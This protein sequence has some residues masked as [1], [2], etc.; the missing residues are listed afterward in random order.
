MRLPLPDRVRERLG[1]RG[2]AL[3]LAL[4]V[5]L[6]LALLL[7]FLT[8]VIPGKGDRPVPSVFG[9]EAGESDAEEADRTP[10]KASERRA[11]SGK[12]R[13][14]P[15]KPA[16]PPPEAPEPPVPPPSLPPDFVR[17][18]RPDFKAA[19]IAGKGS[20]PRA[21]TGEREAEATADSGSH[22]GDSALAGGRGP[23][24]EPLYAA[25]WHRRPTRAELATYISDRARQSGWGLIAC[26]T[27]AN[28][29]VE[30]CQEMG[31]APRGSGLAGSVRQA[32]WQFR[33]RPPRKGGREMVGAWVAIRIDYNLTR[34]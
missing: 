21:D 28:Y 32:A 4:L 29:R 11:E 8:P 9:I 12:P 27:V 1:Q 24:G 31:E 25:E 2:A 15:P 5:E 26:R 22:P 13:P 18:T 23:N 3:V 16:E 17:L 7:L 20:A 19:D 6:L 33:V 10:E 14:V 34:E 30:D